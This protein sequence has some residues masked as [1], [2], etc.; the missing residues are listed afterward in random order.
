MRNIKKKKTTQQATNTLTSESIYDNTQQATGGVMELNENHVQ[1]LIKQRGLIEK[2]CAWADETWTE[3]L[4]NIES[5]VYDL[6]LAKVFDYQYT[7]ATKMPFIKVDGRSLATM[8]E[9]PD[10]ES[11]L[12]YPGEPTWLQSAETVKLPDNVHGYVMTRTSSFRAGIIISGTQVHSLY[13]GKITVLAYNTL[14]IPVTVGKYAR[15]F[16]IKFT[17]TEPEVG[18]RGIWGGDKATTDGVERPW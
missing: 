12:L 10:E 6:A 1:W 17:Q 13:N 15:L 11:W 5:G 7:N 2:P 4:T 9:R 16:S 14:P 3:R 18:Y 8:Q